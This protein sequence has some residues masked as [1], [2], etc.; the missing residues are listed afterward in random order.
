VENMCDPT[1]TKKFN[2]ML[3]KCCRCA[4][5]HTKTVTLC[6]Q[7]MVQLWTA[8]HK[9][10]WLNACEESGLEHESFH[11]L[12]QAHCFKKW[13]S[14]Q[15]VVKVVYQFVFVMFLRPFSNRPDS[16]PRKRECVVGM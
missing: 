3:H 14:W 9:V 5:V 7:D 2:K 8:W 10:M 6:E 15:L 13:N 1:N 16:N 11:W 4:Y 12:R